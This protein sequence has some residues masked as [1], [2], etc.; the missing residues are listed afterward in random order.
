MP[1]AHLDPA[2]A[3]LNRAYQV[4]VAGFPQLKDARSRVDAEHCG[5]RAQRCFQSD[6]L[7]HHV[8]MARMR[9]ALGQIEKCAST[10]APNSCTYYVIGPTR[11]RQ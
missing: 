1:Q 10:T 3:P 11:Q 4:W 6:R 5:H 8:G 7:N 9:E 2:M